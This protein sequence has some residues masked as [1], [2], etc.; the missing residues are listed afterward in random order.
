MKTD[1]FLTEWVMY[2]FCKK[3]KR[4]VSIDKMLKFDRDGDGDGTCKR[5][6][7]E[8]H[9]PLS[10]IV[11]ILVNTELSEGQITGF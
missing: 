4:S 8:C 10:Q 7:R 3:K 2:P 11:V 6:F 9:P 1:R 5:T